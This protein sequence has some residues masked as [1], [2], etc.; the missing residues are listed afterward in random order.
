MRAKKIIPVFL[1]W[2]NFIEIMLYYLNKEILDQDIKANLMYCPYDRAGI[3]ALNYLLLFYT[4][5]RS[6]FIFRTI[7]KKKLLWLKVLIKHPLKSI[8]L[9]GHI[10]GGLLVLH[11]Q[12]CVV[13]ADKVGKNFTVSQCVTVG[14]GHKNKNG[15]DIPRIGNNVRIC[16]NTVVFGGIDIGDNVVI[17]AGSVVNKSVPSNCT[18]V[19]NP[20]RIV[21][22]DGIRCNDLLLIDGD[23]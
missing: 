11:K 12:G 22:R 1:I 4:P 23:Y 17:G 14:K 16:P 10:D 8:E 19:G 3:L 6:V 9:F 20:A 15:R 18:V 5:F 7:T 2:I 21:R 13:L